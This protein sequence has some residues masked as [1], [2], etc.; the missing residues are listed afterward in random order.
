MPTGI[1]GKN[2]NG[3]FAR[4]PTREG[5]GPFRRRYGGPFAHGLS[6]LRHHLKRNLNREVI[7]GRRA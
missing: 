1:T 3:V 7:R 2:G 6:S 5:P 4:G